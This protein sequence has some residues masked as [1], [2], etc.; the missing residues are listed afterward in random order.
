MTFDQAQT[1][2]QRI[3]RG[4]SENSKPNE[5]LQ[6]QRDLDALTDQL[7]GKDGFDSLRSAIDEIYDTL[8]GNIT[9]GVLAQLQLRNDIFKRASEGFATI[10]RQ[11]QQNAKVLSLE[12]AKIVLPALN[13]SAGEIKEIIAALKNNDASDAIARGQSLLALVEKV[14]DE[15]SRV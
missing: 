2:F 11:A 13:Q 4:I 8:V 14:K 5:L 1:E 9:Q 10:G 7:R 6:A 12:K 15:L 3:L